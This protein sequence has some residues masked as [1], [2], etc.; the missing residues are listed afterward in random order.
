MKKLRKLW[1]KLPPW[2]EL[3]LLAAVIIALIAIG[4]AITWA[5][6][7]PLP[8]ID[9]FENRKVAESTKI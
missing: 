5:S 7:V 2:A 4:S 8:S 9:N 3:S 1:R 6:L